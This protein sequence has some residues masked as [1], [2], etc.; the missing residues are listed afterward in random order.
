MSGDEII[1]M[2]N[3]IDVLHDKKKNS[4]LDIPVFQPTAAAAMMYNIQNDSLQRE[5]QKQKLANQ[6]S[7]SFYNRSLS[8]LQGPMANFAGLPINKNDSSAASNESLSSKISEKESDIESSYGKISSS[9]IAQCLRKDSDN[10]S[11]KSFKLFPYICLRCKKEAIL[12]DSPTQTTDQDPEEPDTKILYGNPKSIL[13]DPMLRS[14]T[15]GNRLFELENNASNLKN[16]K[17]QKANSNH[18]KCASTDLGTFK[19]AFLI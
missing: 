15:V 13:A 17:T 12:C 5:K 11:K 4:I 18:H 10:K 19:N 2:E 6:D 14:K 7:S 9:L 8:Y 1:K 3:E 16:I